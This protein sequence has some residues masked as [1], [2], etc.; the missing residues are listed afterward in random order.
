MKLT[1]K[2]LPTLILAGLAF[3]SPSVFATNGY[4]T[5]GVGG[6]MK[7]MAG[8]G[9]GSNADMGPMVVANN[10][11]LAVFTQDNLELGLA[12]FSPRRSYDASA[13]LANGQGGAFT[14]GA[15]EYKSSSNLFGV[16][17]AA[18]N[19]VLQDDRAITLSAYGRGGMNTDWDDNSAFATFDPDGPGPA[20]PGN[21]PGPF[22]GGEAGVDLVQLFVSV[23]YASK[24]SERLAWG[25][26]P[27][28]AVQAFEAKGLGAF[29]PYTQTF[30]ESGGTNMPTNLTGNGHDTSVGLGLSFGLWAGITDRL[31][32]GLSYQTRIEASEFDDYS[33]L[34]ARSGSFDVPASIRGGLSYLARDNLRLNL[35]VEHTQYGEIDSVGNPMSLLAGCPSAQLGGTNFANCL[36]GHDGAGFGWLDMTNYKLGAQWDASGGAQWR[37]GY[38]YGEQPIRGKDALFNIL[39]PGIMEQHYTAGYTGQLSNGREWTI[40]LMYSPE[41]KVKGANMFDPTQSIELKMYE[42]EL[43]FSF[44]F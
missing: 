6:K 29:S 15:G 7:G 12:L 37:L 33:D 18:K 2:S 16:P 36:G 26:G 41:K 42:F 8:A 27:V 5:H 23:N 44:L 17:Y 35:D 19:W 3:T 30:A 13:S 10:P 39:A 24:I 31:S 4:F 38:S 40:A 25:I 32:A 20:S 21:F 9:M 11:A 43:E 34:F 28:L 1:S 14:V 22:G